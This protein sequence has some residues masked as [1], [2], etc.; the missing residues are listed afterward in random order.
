ML[1][2]RHAGLVFFLSFGL[3][4]Q[5]TDGLITGRV[6]DSQSGAALAGAMVTSSNPATH[7]TATARS[8]A[9]G[10]FALPLL[11]PGIYRVRITADAYQAQEVQEL[12]VAVAEPWS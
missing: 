5:T 3:P 8:D 9:A 7:T 6:T 4:G 1:R 12:T 11:P 2:V 10:Y